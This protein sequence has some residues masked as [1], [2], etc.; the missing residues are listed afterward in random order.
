VSILYSPTGRQSEIEAL[1]V[2]LERIRSFVES[3]HW[4]ERKQTGLEKMSQP[5]FWSSPDRFPILGELEYVDRVDGALETTRVLYQK[6]KGL[7]SG[8]R[9]RA[10]LA[11]RLAQAL[12]LLDLA[13]ETVENGL[14]RDAF[15]R[16]KGMK[17]SRE[18]TGTNSYFARHLAQMYQAWANKRRMRLTVLDER[19]GEDNSPYNFLAAVSGF[20]AYLVLSAETGLHVFE[21]PDYGQVPQRAKIQV[22]VIPQAD[23][24]E[25]PDRGDLKQQAQAAFEGDQD[26][27]PAIVR[28][29]RKHPSPLVRDSVRGWRTGRL[30]RVLGGDFDLFG[31]QGRKYSGGS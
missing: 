26:H 30:D 4:R 13:G 11:Q 21:L 8:G 20:G 7:A 23:V 3:D 31:F 29:Y 6:L 18:A 22:Q 19:G 28:R 24:P 12:Y 17:E 5:T 16:L 9:I 15:L 14:P 1:G 25:G 2:H 27:T 10:D